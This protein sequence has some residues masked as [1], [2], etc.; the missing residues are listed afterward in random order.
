MTENAAT[1]QRDVF[2][3]IAVSCSRFSFVFFVFFVVQS[4]LSQAVHR[5]IALTTADRN[6]EQ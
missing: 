5:R 4:W 3:S 2:A 6:G 1:L